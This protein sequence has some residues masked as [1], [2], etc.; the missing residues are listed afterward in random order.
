M[1]KWKIIAIVITVSVAVLLIAAYFVT[2][3]YRRKHEK[4]RISD[5]C[6]SSAT[7]TIFVMMASYKNPYAAAETLTSLFENAHCPLRVYAGVFELY[8]PASSTNILDEYEMQ[9]KFSKSPF[10]LR[11]HV[12]TIRI[13]VNENK[14]ILAAHEQIER[15]LY[16]GEKFV[17]S[18]LPGM[19]VTPSWDK[20]CIDVLRGAAVST[21]HTKNILTA[22]SAGDVPVLTSDPGTYVGLHDDG[23]LL[24]YRM[25]HK[26][27]VPFV[28]ALGWSSEFSFSDAVRIHDTPYERYPDEYPNGFDTVLHDMYMTIRL[29]KNGWETLHPTGALVYNRRRN[30]DASDHNGSMAWRDRMQAVNR[31][32]GTGKIFSK[33]GVVSI[34]D[35][36]MGLSARARLGLTPKADDTEIIGKVGSIGEYLS[37]L[38]RLDLKNK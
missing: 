38:S 23:S 19:E 12:R 9:T 34:G 27:T 29:L 32:R 8:D 17:A 4:I 28:P 31:A 35:N 18:I 11:D 2:I 20:Y 21:K 30:F 1:E 3:S 15:F 14:G 33:L 25:K 26:S 6:Q 13:P 37:I 5:A 16:R 10:C 7:D 24:G 36:K 22:M